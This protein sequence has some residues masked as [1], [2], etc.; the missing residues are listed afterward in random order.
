M[1]GALLGVGTDIG[2]MSGYRHLLAAVY[3]TARMGTEMLTQF[4]V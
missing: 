2:G 3:F 1:R 4:Y